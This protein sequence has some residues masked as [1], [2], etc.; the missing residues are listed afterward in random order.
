MASVI[1]SESITAIVAESTEGTAAAP[2]SATD[3]YTQIKDDGLDLA[4]TQELLERGIE[5][6]SLAKATPQLGMKGGTAA[7]QSEL[8]AS[9]TEGSAP[10]FGQ[11]LFSLL[12]SQTTIATANTSRGVGQNTG[13]LVAIE[14]ADIGDYAVGDMVVVKE[15]GE[16]RAHAVTAVVTTGGSESITVLPGKSSGNFTDA[17]VVSKSH[18][19]KAADTGHDSFTF[20][21]Y[22]GDATLEQII[23]CRTTSMSI[24]NFTTGQIGSLSFSAQGMSRTNTASTSASHTPT[25]DT[26]LPAVFLGACVFQDGASINVNEVSLSVD[27]PISQLKA[28]CDANGVVSQHLS[29][30]RSITGSF[31]VYATDSSV[32]QY[33]GFDNGTTFTMV[34]YAGV[35]SS[36]AGELTLGTIVAFYMPV[37]LRTNTKREDADGIVTDVVEFMATGGATGTSSELSI[38]FI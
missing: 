15:A 26:A 6:S 20:N 22:H 5:T 37:C 27:Q 29:Q 25:Y 4:G 13:T 24:D 31:P 21:R 8:R 12:G 35:P 19:Y 32:A 9:G 10:D 1:K 11:A 7:W 36:T 33:T 34:F 14:A 23:G 30:K 16:F 38:G 28:T 3:G 17:V 2:A 18:T